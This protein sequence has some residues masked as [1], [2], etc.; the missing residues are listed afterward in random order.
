MGTDNSEYWVSVTTESEESEDK[1]R[2]AVSACGLVHKWTMEQVKKEWLLCPDYR[3]KTSDLMPGMTTFLK[4]TEVLEMAQRFS[5]LTTVSRAIV[6]FYREMKVYKIG[7]TGAEILFPNLGPPNSYQ[8]LD[9]QARTVWLSYMR[10]Y[11]RI[12]THYGSLFLEEGWQKILGEHA[13]TFSVS[14]N[15]YPHLIY[16]ATV[17]ESL[18]GWRVYFNLHLPHSKQG[19]TRIKQSWTKT[20]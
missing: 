1:M 20:K 5:Y 11:G 3:V 10:D 2:Q 16:S 12:S 19:K 13:E 14:P 15:A 4:T 7:S 18:T 9:I 17:K 6:R 8:L